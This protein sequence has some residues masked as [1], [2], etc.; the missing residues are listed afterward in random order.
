MAY[1]EL[2]HALMAGDNKTEAGHVI[3][4]ALQ[5]LKGTVHEGRVLLAQVIT[6]KK[7]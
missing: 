1:V 4:E 2:F 7:K 5:Q 6:L 3:H